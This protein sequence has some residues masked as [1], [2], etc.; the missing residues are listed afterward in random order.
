MMPAP[1]WLKCMRFTT[2]ELFCQLKVNNANVI[3]MEITK[4]HK[5]L[6]NNKNSTSIIPSTT[7]HFF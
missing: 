3:S 7:S 2:I 6:N 5:K 4:S 1:V